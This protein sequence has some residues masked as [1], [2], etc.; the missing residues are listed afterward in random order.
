MSQTSLPIARPFDAWARLPLS[1]NKILMLTTSPDIEHELW[2]ALEYYSEVEEVGLDLIQAKGLQSPPTHQEIFNCFQAF[3]RQA[4]SYYSSAKTLHYRSSSLLYYYCFLNL[5]KAYLLLIQPQR[6]TGLKVQH[7]LIYDPSTTNKDFQLEVVGVRQGIFP[8]FYKAQTANVI[9]PAIDSS[10]NIVNLLS[11]PTEISYQYRLAR[12]GYL[13][14][15]SSIAV[16]AVDRPNNQSWIIL[17]IPAATSLDGFL[18]LHVNFLN[19]YQ[20]V[21]PNKDQLAL[22]FG[23]SVF[24]LF[25]FRFFQEITTTPTHGNNDFINQPAFAQKIINDLSPYYSSHYFDDNKDFDLVLPYADSTH[26]TPIPITEA[27]SIYAVMFYLSSLVR[28]RPDYL[29]ALLNTKPAWLIE[30]FVNSTPE[31]FLRIMISK[32]IETDFVFRRR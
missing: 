1:N 22:V 6:I 27:L 5:V 29:E 15:L 13:N 21:Q 19:T 25:S 23:M 28:Y 9:S 3:V 14:I 11:Y 10:I 32:I 24:E 20:E 16:V 18:S 30:N 8:M 7:G 26:P 31:T 17:G 4:K 2:S 12:Y